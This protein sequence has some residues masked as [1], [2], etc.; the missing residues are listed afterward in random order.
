MQPVRVVLTASF[1]GLFGFTGLSANY[2]A[3]LSATSDIKKKE[4]Q[5][6]M[7]NSISTLLTRTS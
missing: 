7:P 4:N 5:P 2:R 1:L 6:N 3:P